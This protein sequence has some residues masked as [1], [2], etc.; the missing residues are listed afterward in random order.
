MKTPRTDESF[1]SAYYQASPE[2][3]EG[4]DCFARRIRYDMETMEGEIEELKGKSSCPLLSRAHV[5]GIVDKL[6]HDLVAVQSSVGLQF[7]IHQ[8]IT[9]YCKESRQ[10]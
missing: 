5:T 9:E 2:H 4:W 7:H 8:I 3:G 6:S 1:D 10:K